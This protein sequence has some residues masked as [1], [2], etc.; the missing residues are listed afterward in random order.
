LL[1]AAKGDSN[2]SQAEINWVFDLTVADGTSEKLIEELFDIIKMLV[3][4]VK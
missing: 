4:E 3:I 1:I 2:I